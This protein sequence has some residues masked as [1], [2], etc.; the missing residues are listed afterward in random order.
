MRR[1]TDREIFALAQTLD[2]KRC[3]SFLIRPPEYNKLDYWLRMGC[4]CRVADSM[5]IIHAHHEATYLE[6]YGL[7]P[8]QSTG[9][10]TL[11]C[12]LDHITPDFRASLTTAQFKTVRNEARKL[13]PRQVLNITWKCRRL[14]PGEAPD[15]A[16]HP[17]TT[18]K[19]LREEVP[20]MSDVEADAFKGEWA[21]MSHMESYQIAFSC[22][23]RPI[24]DV[25]LV[26]DL[27]F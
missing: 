27:C 19:D 23:L 6:H 9:Q 13:A 17:R 10:M 15:V 16:A 11:Q 26:L 22:V 4:A 1:L 2:V 18:F 14:T 24:C 5:V 7:L 8:L 21:S 3:Q 25:T 12:R 20:V